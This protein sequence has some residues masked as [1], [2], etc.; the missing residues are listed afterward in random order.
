[1]FKIYASSAGPG[2]TYTLSRE[3]MK[4]SLMNDPG[5]GKFNPFYFKHILAVTFTNFAAN[6]M[7]ERILSN[8]EKL[9]NY[10]N[11]DPKSQKKLNPLIEQLL[12]AINEIQEEKL[13]KSDLIW[14]SQ[15]IFSTIIHHYSD[16]S[17]S[18]IDSFVQRVV[19]AFSEELELP[20]NF[21]VSIEQEVLLAAAIEK[22]VTKIGQTQSGY[23]TKA[24]VQFVGNKLEN[25][26][27]WNTV[28]EELQV[29]GR[30]VLDEKFEVSLSKINQLSTFEILQI[31]KNLNEYIKNCRHGLTQKANQILEIIEANS[32]IAKDFYQGSKGL[33]S[34]LKKFEADFDLEDTTPNKYVLEGINDGKFYTKKKGN[35]SIENTIDSI[36]QSL[37]EA[38]N[39]IEGQKFEMI[40]KFNL[41]NNLQQHF[42]KISLLAEIKTELDILQQEN[43]T[44]HISNFNKAIFKIV[45]TEP[46]PFIYERLGERYQHLLIDEFQDTSIVQW[47]NFLPLISNSLGYGNFNLAVGDAKQAIYRWRGGEMEQ[48]VHLHE[49]KINKLLSK[50]DPG[51]YLKD[52]YDNLR[53][54]IL[55]GSLNTNYRSCKEIIAFNNQLF[56]FIKNNY[57]GKFPLLTSVYNQDFKQETPPT[58]LSGGHIQIDLHQEKIDNWEEEIVSK[59]EEITLQGFNFSDIAILCRGNKDA[60]KVAIYLK[61][62]GIDVVSEDSLLL[63]ASAI[64]NFV[65][66][67][68]QVIHSPQMALVKYQ[69]IYLYFQTLQNRVPNQ[70]ESLLIKEAI[71]DPSGAA[72]FDFFEKFDIK[73]DQARF[74][75]STVYEMVE[76]ILK[77][78]DLYEQK[79]ELNYIFRFL[80]VVI[81]FSS[82]KSGHLIDFLQYWTEKKDKISI[83]LSAT[84]NAIK[85][86]SIHKSKGLEFPVVI[87]PNCQ[88]ETV[89][90]T[91]SAMYVSLAEM[92]YPELEIS[93][94]GQLK[95]LDVGLVTINKELSETQLSEVYATEME[96]TFIENI[97]LLYVALTRPTHRLYLIINEKLTESKAN[98]P[99][100]GYLLRDFLTEKNLYHNTTD[101]CIFEQG[102]T[103]VQDKPKSKT[104]KTIEIENIFVND[105]TQKLKLRTTADKVFDLEEFKNSKDWG[106]KVHEALALVNTKADIDDALF[107]SLSK[108]HISKE[109]KEKM[110]KSINEVIEISEIKMLYSTEN[111]IFNEKEI[112]SKKGIYRTDRTVIL[113]DGSVFIVDYK[114]G[115]KSESHVKQVAQYLRL[116]R[117]MGYENVKGVL[118]YL[119]NLEIEWVA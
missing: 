92:P 71:E 6:E 48:I 81:E 55:A 110:E 25:G 104:E 32:L 66:S 19:K 33:H 26:K 97:N 41:F 62:K 11:L 53:G 46:I 118:V 74:Q 80:D 70:E 38:I 111:Q 60:K 37:I 96:R 72:F 51:E 30:D 108:G 67:I 87:V 10:Y 20:F 17:V 85:V 15:Q 79:N 36:A 90:K 94:N 86:T 115:Q 88:W 34:Y 100:V 59:I 42:Y 35:T 101:E 45:S 103:F 107:Y 89:P 119:Q 23:L 13:G 29:F 8:F 44:I 82:T 4:L 28:A 95:K 114:T 47:Q 31:R 5:R 58:P 117:L 98:T 73:I 84:A 56:E 52:H 40:P 77:Y 1:M 69:A 113:P 2:K 54:Q 112:L 116:Y 22:L 68:L 49:K 14:R 12:E 24:I 64:I 18:T 61:N 57:A 43:A 63:S 50:N 91:G 99:H 65:I 93:N 76:F 3:Y 106:N 16:F 39:E 83:I 75:Q 27:S 21:E 78:F 7:K 9:G 102:N 105:Y 109:E